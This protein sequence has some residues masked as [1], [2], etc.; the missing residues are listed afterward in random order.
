[1]FAD[2]RRLLQ[3]HD[4]GPRTVA[5]CRRAVA[6]AGGA[7]HLFHDGIVDLVLAALELRPSLE[8]RH[9]D[10]EGDWKRMRRCWGIAGAEPDAHSMRVLAAAPRDSLKAAGR[11]YRVR[12]SRRMRQTTSR[13]AALC[14]ARWAAANRSKTGV[15]FGRLTTIGQRSRIAPSARPRGSTR[16]RS[17]FL[18]RRWVHHCRIHARVLVGASQA[19]TPAP[20]QNSSTRSKRLTRNSESSPGPD[21]F[22][23]GLQAL[24]GFC[25]RSVDFRS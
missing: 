6:V 21:G 2:R 9:G 13:P 10:L 22:P 15:K 3:W 4:A 25:D 12:M 23:E 18:K 5:G 7:E 20:N 11:H 16:L 17:E 19:S 24:E 1:M 14:A 8:R